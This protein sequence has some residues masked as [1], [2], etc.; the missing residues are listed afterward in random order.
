MDKKKYKDPILDPTLAGSSEHL[1]GL[2]FTPGGTPKPYEY[3]VAGGGGANLT[4]GLTEEWD[5]PGL[6]IVKLPETLNFDKCKDYSV[7]SK[8]HKESLAGMES[9]FSKTIGELEK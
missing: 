7:F 2:G 6:F 1:Q 9:L 3:Q 4:P 8:I 5:D